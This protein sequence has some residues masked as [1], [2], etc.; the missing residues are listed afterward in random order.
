M[1]SERSLTQKNSFNLYEVLEQ[2]KLI[3]GAKKT[4]QGE[5]LRIGL[6]IDWDEYR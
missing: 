3:C 4:E 5:T 1:L 6:G 2:A